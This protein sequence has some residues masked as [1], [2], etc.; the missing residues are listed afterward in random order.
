MVIVQIALVND[1]LVLARLKSGSDNL[2][3]TT[4]LCCGYDVQRMQQTF[5]VSTLWCDIRRQYEAKIT[6]MRQVSAARISGSTNH[7][8]SNIVDVCNTSLQWPTKVLP[9][10]KLIT[11]GLKFMHPMLVT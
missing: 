9:V 4:R 8:S 11:K 1:K 2:M 7:K 6:G 5:L 3:V 10:L